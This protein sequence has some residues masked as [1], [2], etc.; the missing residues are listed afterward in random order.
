MTAKEF[1]QALLGSP[2]IAAIM[3]GLF[4]V[5]SLRMGLKRFRSER[6]WERKA[7]A[8]TTVMGHLQ[9][10][11]EFSKAHMEAFEGEYSFSQ[12]EERWRTAIVSENNEGWAGIR[13]WSNIGSFVMTKRSASILSELIRKMNE[14][15]VDGPDDEYHAARLA[16][17]FDAIIAMK[18][19]AKADLII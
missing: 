7:E 1:L 18:V 16:L 15:P 11:Y 10:M 14:L 3:V 19:E 5:I 2:V 4:T 6:W 8:Y 12:I 13:K 17:L 9:A